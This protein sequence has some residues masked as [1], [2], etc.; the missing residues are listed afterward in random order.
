[1]KR[2][3]ILISI[4]LFGSCCNKNQDDDFAYS[5]M[6]CVSIIEKYGYDC[7]SGNFD[8]DFDTAMW[9]YCDV[10]DYLSVLTG[11]KYHVIYVDVPVYESE[12]AVQQDI[13]YLKRWYEE[14][15]RNMTKEDAD[16][17]V[18]KCYENH[19]CNLPNIDSVIVQWDKKMREHKHDNNS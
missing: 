5:Y 4:L 16:S 9:L 19:K 17:I 3:C 2:L 10:S 6:K 13:Q 11:I 12:F 15:G 7:C 14:Y 8:I 18:R 1:M